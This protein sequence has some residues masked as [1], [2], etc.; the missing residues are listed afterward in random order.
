MTISIKDRVFKFTKEDHE[1]I[2]TGKETQKPALTFA[3][4]LV[5]YYAVDKDKKTPGISKPWSAETTFAKYEGIYNNILLR[6]LPRA[7]ALTDYDIDLVRDVFEQMA[8]ENE[9]SP[10]YWKE[11]RRLFRIVYDAGLR[12]GDV[13]TDKLSGTAFGKNASIESKE[14]M[15]KAILLKKSFSAEEDVLILARLMKGARRMAGS[16][17]GVRM[18]FEAGLRNGEAAGLDYKHIREFSTIPGMHKLQSVQS[19]IPGTNRLQSGG[20]TD[21][22]P[23]YVPI[24]AETYHLIQYRSRQLQ[25]TLA[26]SNDALVKMPVVARNDKGVRCSG[27]DINKE[28]KR[29]FESIQDIAERLGVLDDVIFEQRFEIAGVLEKDPTAY[30]FRRNAAT[31]MHALGLSETEIQYCLGHFLDDSYSDRRDYA[32]EEM[33]APIARKMSFRPAVQGMKRFKGFSL[34][35][36]EHKVRLQLSPSIPRIEF[37]N[38]E[39]IEI[40][41][42]SASVDQEI[43]LDVSALEPQDDVSCEVVS[44]E[45]EAVLETLSSQHE[46]HYPGRYVNCRSVFY[47]VYNKYMKKH[48]VKLFPHH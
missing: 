24:S 30:A 2:A 15:R 36:I 14:F 7:T 23:R 38:E 48:Q 17:L 22:A 40:I 47:G 45:G 29:C 18:M 9:Y 32:N 28:A 33:L 34:K 37:D 27:E 43:I 35:P 31:E 12:N 13:R 44:S 20:K 25:H 19:V 16:R 42:P 26:C 6:Y 46:P 21:N 39:Y 41:I 5:K 4:V 8:N 10:T 3:G 11:I 1:L